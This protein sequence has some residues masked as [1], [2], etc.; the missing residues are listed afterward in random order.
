M[1]T[2]DGSKR[3]RCH[4]CKGHKFSKGGNSHIKW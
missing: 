4:V 2:H 3:G 1:D